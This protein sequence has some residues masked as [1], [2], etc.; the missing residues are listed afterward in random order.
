MNAVVEQ[1]ELPV[2]RPPFAPVAPSLLH[3]KQFHLFLI[4]T[5]KNHR[6]S[7]EK[8]TRVSSNQPGASTRKCH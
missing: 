3:E 8:Q 4:K 2:N 6:A 5:Q 1:K 7:S